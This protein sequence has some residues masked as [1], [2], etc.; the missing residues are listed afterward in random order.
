[1]NLKKSLAFLVLLQVSLFSATFNVNTA[2]ELHQALEDTA[3]N[4]ENDTI[5]LQPGTYSTDSNGLGTFMFNDTEEY[6]LTIKG[7]DGYGMNDIVLDGNT[8]Y[9]VMNFTNSKSFTLKIENL[10]IFNGK[11]GS[12][13]GGLYTTGDIIVKDCNISN[14][15]ASNGGG[16]FDASD[17]TI[18]NSTISNNSASN[19]GG[20]YANN[21][22]ITNSTISNNSASTDGGGFYAS[23]T[24][25]TNSTISNNSAGNYGGG[26][27][28][29][30]TTV[31]N[32]TISSNFAKHNGGGFYANNT[33]V[34]NSTISHNSANL[35][36][37]GFYTDYNIIVINSTIS[38][39]SAGYGYGGGGFYTDYN[40]IV[41]N[42]NFINNNKNLV[43]YGVFI[44]NIF[45]NDGIT[46][47]G[48]SKLYHNYIDYSKLSENNHIIVKKSNLLPT[49]VGDIN[50]ADD[51]IT[52][53]STSPAI[54]AGLN[55]TTT[56]FGNALSEDDYKKVLEYLKTDYFGNERIVNGK[57]D[58]GASEYGATAFNKNKPKITIK[59]SGN[60][61]IYSTITVNIDINSS[62]SISELDI[63]KGDGYKPVATTLKSFT[64]TYDLAGE[65]N[66]KIKVVDVQGNIAELT[67][68]I[69]IYDLTTQEAI[70][71]GKKLCQKD[72]VS[73]GIAENSTTTQD[74]LDN[75][76]F[77]NSTSGW[78]LLGSNRD[79]TPSEIFSKNPQVSI[80]WIYRDGKWQAKGANSRIDIAI[81]SNRNI[82]ILNTIENG[83]GFWIYTKTQ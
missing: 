12:N 1:M 82:S 66:I 2:L 67:K 53:Q 68:S 26:F 16:G 5:I 4:G 64:V 17:T 78:R 30:N 20:F 77:T 54:D 65:H 8:T 23:D 70:E 56:L 9:Q 40:S 28:A 31:T 73:C 69:T 22:T 76:K 24:T 7:A 49:D 45:I 19:S 74:I 58:I 75:Q 52:L 44:N 46:F 13:G 81:S 11:S 42:S 27:Y 72:P 79:L 55:P 50:F 62:N 57:I 38:N 18:T 37:G 25:I 35:N 63:D 41:I 36:G 59:L 33:T 39:N 80:V 51:N 71:Y 83:D 47:D 60:Q 21:T 61:K 14:N 6:N 3:L 29:I 10:S 15:S 48:N 43:A 32:S 34:T